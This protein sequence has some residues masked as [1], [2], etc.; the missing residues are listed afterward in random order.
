[1][2]NYK[3]SKTKQQQ[4]NQNICNLDKGKYRK[5]VNV[6]N[7]E[8]RKICTLNF[9]TSKISCS[10][11]NCWENRTARYKLEENI[12]NTYISQKPRIQNVL[13]TLTTQKSVLWTDSSKTKWYE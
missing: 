13:R 2:L 11:K 10:S 9:I 4:K 5:I 1:M 12:Y 3:P 7:I 6:L 8:K